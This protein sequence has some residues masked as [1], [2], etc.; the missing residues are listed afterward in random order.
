MD[1]IDAQLVAVAARRCGVISLHDLGTLG[2]GRGIAM[3]Q[4]RLGRWVPVVDDV[5]RMAAFPR[6]WCQD[7]TI[8]CAALDEAAVVSHRSAALL[9][10]LTPGF[11]PCVAGVGERLP[12]EV[13]V[14]GPVRRFRQPVPWQAYRLPAGQW[15]LEAVDVMVDFTTGLEVTSPA[16]TVVDLSTLSLGEAH[17][18]VAARNALAMGVTPGE[19]LARSDAR[20]RKAGARYP[21]E[22]RLLRVLSGLGEG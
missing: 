9:H 6:S 3:K 17:L 5:W 13:L 16:R 14:G 18:R 19:I 11:P 12:V 15:E 21:G 8:A 10:R 2:L 4:V 7:L 1:D 22:R 20:P